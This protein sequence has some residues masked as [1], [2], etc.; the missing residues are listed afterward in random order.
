MSKQF[1]RYL[2]SGI[3]NTA[4]GYTIIFGMML[5][6]FSPEISNFVGF[7]TGLMLSFL[8]NRYWVFRSQNQ[9]NLFFEIIRFLSAFLFCYGLNYISLIWLIYSLGINPYIAQLG[10]GVIYFLSFFL[11]NKWLV[12]NSS[13]SH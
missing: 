6:S 11:L 7:L 4:T 12:F 8:L 3:L 10:A 13:L 1:F 5:F 2:I 9:S